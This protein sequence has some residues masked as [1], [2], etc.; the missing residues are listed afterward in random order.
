MIKTGLVLDLSNL[1]FNIPRVFGKGSKLHVTSLLENIEKNG[2]TLVSKVA[3]SNQHADDAH[4]FVGLL[5]VH[6]IETFFDNTD[7]SIAIALKVAE[8]CDIVDSIIIC[9]SN[10]QMWRLM[11]YAKTRGKIVKCMSVNIPHWF[12][13]YGQCLELSSEVI[14]LKK[15]EDSSIGQEAV[16]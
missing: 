14:E 12:K 13:Q 7:W 15:F 16:A 3:Y 5:K 6:G 9:T 11:H 4:R 2:H 1:Y 8:L 10:I